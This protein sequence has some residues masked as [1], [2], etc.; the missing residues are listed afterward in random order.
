M[1]KLIIISLVDLSEYYMKMD[2]SMRDMYSIIPKI[3]G[4][5]KLILI[6]LQSVRGKMVSYMETQT[7]LFGLLIMIIKLILLKIKPDGLKMAAILVLRKRILMN[8]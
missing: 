6:L 8:L 1:V 7:I 4:A 2:L 5:D 3:T